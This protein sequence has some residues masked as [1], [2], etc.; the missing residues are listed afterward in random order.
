MKRNGILTLSCCRARHFQKP[1]L[2]ETSDPKKKYA[3]G[4]LQFLFC[5]SDQHWIELLENIYIVCW[6][7]SSKDSKL[8][9]KSE[10]RVSEKHILQ[11]PT[12]HSKQVDRANE[13]LLSEFLKI[14][15]K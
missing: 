9:L 7:I 13:P 11:S 10:I 1:I 4:V 14:F 12:R 2:E 3:R 8:G 6:P 5:F 15:T